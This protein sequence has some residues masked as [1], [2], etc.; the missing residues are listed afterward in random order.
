MKKSLIA[1]SIAFL[2][3]QALASTSTETHVE[4]KESSILESAMEKLANTADVAMGKTEDAIK[5]VTTKILDKEA[6]FEAVKKA[7][8]TLDIPT[9]DATLGKSQIGD[10]VEVSMKG[11]EGSLYFAKDGGSFIAG[12]HM[13]IKDGK[14]VSAQQLKAFDKLEEIAKT[15]IVHKAADEKHVV[16]VFFDPTCSF[17]RKLYKEMQTY[18]DK[19]IT[20]RLVGFPREGLDS[21]LATQMEAVFTSE[22]PVQALKDMEDGKLPTTLK[23]PN[24]VKSHYEYGLEYGVRGTPAIITPAGNLLPGYLP[25]DTL[26]E[27]LNK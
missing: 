16:T 13:L 26:L 12:Q 18:N 27:E 11:A 23:E 7:L 5:S 25:A 6:D 22:N 9:E 21:K 17:C 1:L 24:V 4:V 15:A 3:A 10:L 14:V 19:G 2:S 20:V 8:A